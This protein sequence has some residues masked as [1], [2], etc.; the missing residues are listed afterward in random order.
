MNRTIK[1]IDKVGIVT[2]RAYAKVA[3]FLYQLRRN[4]VIRV[5]EQRQE[6]LGKANLKVVIA[7]QDRVRAKAEV[8]EARRALA[9]A[10]RFN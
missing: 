1:A 7:E 6:A 4:A 10:L 3:D 5:I 9:E 2:Y 8:V